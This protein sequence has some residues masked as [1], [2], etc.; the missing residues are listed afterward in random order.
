M[1]EHVLKLSHEKPTVLVCEYE[2]PNPGTIFGPV[3][4][5][6]YIIE[7]NLSGYGG[8][9]INGTL[10]PVGPGDCYILLPGDTVTHITDKTHPRIGY[11]CAVNGLSLWRYLRAAGI[12]S[13]TPF[14]SPDARNEIQH[15]MTEMIKVANRTDSAADLFQT[16]CVYGILAALHK[17]VS[18][19]EIDLL[20]DKA[21]GIIETN[22]PE[23][24]SVT[25]LAN[26]IGFSRTYFSEVFKRKTGTTPLAYLNTVRLEN[27]AL[28][29]S[30]N[31]GYS[32][33]Q[34]ANS[35]GIDEKNFSRLFKK[36]FGESP[37]Q[38]RKLHEKKEVSNKTS[39]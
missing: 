38:Y 1:K 6:H 18:L 16:A 11:W 39:P 30:N 17:R 5:K 32:I 14:T 13:Q 24:I 8:V 35:V 28:L 2:E 7:C 37:L 22:Y 15:W 23:P 25:Y 10:F 26:K 27:A 21:I 4:R 36:K 9:I 19:S 29:L 12:T 20:I 3:I 33:T 34:V 31:T